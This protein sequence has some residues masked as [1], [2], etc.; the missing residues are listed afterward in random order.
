MTIT[1]GESAYLKIAF[2]N[3]NPTP[4][5]YTK[6]L[7]SSWDFVPDA[8]RKQTISMYPIM[9][10]GA[11]GLNMK[12]YLDEKIRHKKLLAKAHRI[13]ARNKMSQV[14]TSTTEEK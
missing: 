4:A 6:T 3:G 2:E 5:R 10:T 1:K 12:H 7:K 9:V 8:E 14:V 13:L 11:M